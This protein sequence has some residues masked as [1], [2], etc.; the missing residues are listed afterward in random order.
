VVAQL[1]RIHAIQT[2]IGK[3][4]QQNVACSGLGKA[5]RAQIEQRILIDL[6]DSRAVSALHV[7][8]VD[9]KLR[10]GIDL[11]IV[12]EQQITVGLLGVSFL[13][14]FMDDDAPVK[15]AVRLAV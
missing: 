11:R 10:L 2:F 15:Y 9:F 3:R 13:C 12:R 8:C 5:A 7:V 4:Q 1:R 14:V 6:A